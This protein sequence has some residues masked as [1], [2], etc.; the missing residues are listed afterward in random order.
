MRT[1]W[2]LIMLL[3]SLGAT[4]Q[5]PILERTLS[6]SLEDESLASALEKIGA[7]AGFSFSYSP[8][9]ITGPARVTLRI[10]NKT[11][12][13]V[14][15]QIFQ[16]TVHY[17]ART[18]HLILTQASVP[19]PKATTAIV[20]QGY[21]VQRGSDQKIAQASVYDKTSLSAA[22]TDDYGFFRLNVEKEGDPLRLF[23]SKEG[24]ADTVWTIDEAKNQFVTVS[25]SRIAT[26][27]QVVPREETP[28]DTVTGWTPEEVDSVFR[29][30]RFMP[31]Q[32]RAA[33]RNIRDTLYRDVQ[34]SLLPFVGN[35]GMLSG[36]V[37]NDYS[38]N[39]L[40][41]YSLG[42]R[43]IELG[44]FV[45]IDRGDVRWLQI[46]GFTNLVGGSV[47]G[48]RGLVLPM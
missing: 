31:Y 22:T 19:A 6:L 30:E 42:I 13:D 35:H 12:R 9:V 34:I 40:G 10:E 2:L 27:P 45:N 15:N 29:Q 39:V 48:F 38:L 41:G 46:A 3:G 8:A 25:L 7:R 17:K 11:V 21:V 33:I 47:N 44:F 43:Q 37:I 20:I 26:E 23:V 1:A 5:T 24:Y 18:N 36:N 32:Q 16:G 4:A 28:A 14:L